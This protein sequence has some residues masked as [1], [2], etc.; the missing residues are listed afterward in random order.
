MLLYGFGDGVANGYVV[1]PGLA[2][3]AG[4]DSG[5]DVGAI[6]DALACV[7]GAG[8]TGDALYEKSCV[9]VDED[10]HG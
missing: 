7:E 6:V 8:F 4:G 1:F 9:L 5:D 2:A 10:T 3:F